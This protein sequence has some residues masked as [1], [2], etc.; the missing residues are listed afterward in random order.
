MPE[1]PWERMTADEKLDELHRKIEMLIGTVNASATR[2]NET[3]SRIADRLSQLERDV[4]ALGTAI[5]VL[6]GAHQKQ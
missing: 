4:A 5:K 3:F 2:G 6:L 1:K